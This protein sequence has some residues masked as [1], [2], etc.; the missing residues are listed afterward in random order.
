MHS[1]VPLNIDWRLPC[2]PCFPVSLVFHR[3]FFLPPSHITTRVRKF[4]LVSSNSGCL[5]AVSALS[6]CSSSDISS[7]GVSYSD[8][9]SFGSGSH[10]FR[11]ITFSLLMKF[12][13]VSISSCIS[14]CTHP[15]HCSF[16]SPTTLDSFGVGKF[17]ICCVL[18]S[19]L[20]D[21][22]SPVK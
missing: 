7:S 12:T 1:L 20:G 17:L 18:T 16:L 8:S 4:F 19:S 2:P 13:R 10:A 3:C 22:I 21:V 6:D 14:P 5:L 11:S 9:S 15:S